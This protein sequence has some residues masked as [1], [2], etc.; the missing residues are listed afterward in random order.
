MRLSSVGDGMQGLALAVLALIALF[1]V[2]VIWGM[3]KSRNSVERAAFGI[4]GAGI[5]GGFAGVLAEVPQSIWIIVGGVIVVAGLLVAR[6][7]SYLDEA[8]SLVNA[9]QTTAA[10]QGDSHSADGPAGKVGE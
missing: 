7:A 5:L 9:R 4:G 2:L 1:V 3:V 8:F 6:A 10:S